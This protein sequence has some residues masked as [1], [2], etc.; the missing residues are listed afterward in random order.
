MQKPTIIAREE[1]SQN[2]I[3]LI[4]TSEL[5]TFIIRD[6][7]NILLSEVTAQCRTEYEQANEE[8]MKSQQEDKTK[9]GLVTKLKELKESED[10]ENGS[11]SV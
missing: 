2:L 10:D 8:Y 7:L 5:P 6:I 9:E 4:N 3:Q 11:T 1:F